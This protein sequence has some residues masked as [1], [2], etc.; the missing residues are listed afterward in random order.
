MNLPLEISF[1]DVAKTP[2]LEDLIR[3]K[4]AKLEDVCDH[5]SSCRVAI[6]TRQH[7]QHRGRPYRIRIDI[8]VPPGHEIVVVREP[9]K[10][11]MHSDLAAE[12]R[13]AFQAAWRQLRDL[14][15]KQRGDTK[16]HPQQE[17][18]AVVDRLFPM[19]GTGFLRTLDGRD[20][21]FHRNS[22]LH[23]DYDRLE[24][25]TGVTFSEELGEKGPQATT[26]RIVDHPY[27]PKGIGTPPA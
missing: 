9:S 6:E 11:D 27:N 19:N 20:I 21:F 1:R 3:E 5:I 2:E 24:V 22:V 4:A 26:V 12:I 14:K 17:I 7:H 23:G 8:T 25:G 16:T 10:G 18:Q 15:E 13:D